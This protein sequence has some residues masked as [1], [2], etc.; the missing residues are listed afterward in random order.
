MHQRDGSSR[1]PTIS[2]DFAYTKASADGQ[3]VKEIESLC[4][5]VMVGSRTGYVGCIPVAN[6]N[7]FAMMVQEVLNFTQVLGHSEIIYRCDNEPSLKQL[8]DLLVRA[9]QQLGLATRKAAPAAYSH[10]DSLCENSVQRVRN[11]ACSL[12]HNV[13]KRLS[14]ILSSEHG[15]WTWAMRHA[16][17][18]LNRFCPVQGSTPFEL[19]Y[20]KQ[21]RGKLCEFSEPVFAYCK[22]PFKGNP[23]WQRMICIGKVESQDSFILYDG[24]QVRLSRSI[25]RI[26]SDWKFYMGFFLNFRAPTWDFK[27]GYGG[28][29]I[30]TKERL[31][32]S[33]ASFNP[34]IGQILPSGFHDEEAEAVQAKAQEEKREQK[35]VGAM[36]LEDPL[37]NKQLFPLEIA[38]NGEVVEAGAESSDADIV[39]L[40]YA[41]TSPADS[42]RQAADEPAASSGTMQAPATPKHSPTV[43]PHGTETV[44]CQ[45]SKRAK[46]EDHKK[47]WIN[48]VR[49]RNE[50][51]I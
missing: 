47:Q 25:G 2:F 24:N 39:S 16:A 13:Q 27:T 19:V 12:M 6:K 43:R 20:N 30:P 36:G 22:T 8:Q 46:V 15:L 37:F 31:S 1:A 28:R 17:W 38:G 34:P 4:T 26:V 3:Q 51:C 21:Y 23:T 11:L 45:E 35:E 40:S 32:A 14:T 18:L 5:L 48:M 49:E 29:V 50:Q 42:P 41:P 44:D 7:Q 10:G 33:S 9:R